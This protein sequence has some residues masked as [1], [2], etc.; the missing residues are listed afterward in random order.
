MHVFPH[1]HT[2]I[3]SL[4]LIPTNTPCLKLH[5]PC[6]LSGSQALNYKVATHS[7]FMDTVDREW[8]NQSSPWGENWHLG[9]TMSTTTRESMQG[10][11]LCCTQKHLFLFSVHKRKW[12]LI[13]QK[14]TGNTFKIY[15]AT[16]KLL[17]PNIFFFSL[18]AN[19]KTYTEI[20]VLIQLIHLSPL[21][22][23]GIFSPTYTINPNKHNYIFV[24]YTPKIVWV[25]G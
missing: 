20:C 8:E 10:S 2:C 23:S 13:S 21:K 6:K 16:E 15:L 11:S 25:E 3:S 5:L 18:Y 22:S 12:P 19:T 14:L 17:L 1:V 9:S 7:S 24:K 4:L